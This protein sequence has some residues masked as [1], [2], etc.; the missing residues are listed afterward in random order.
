MRAREPE[1]YADMYANEKQRERVPQSPSACLCWCVNSHI[2]PLGASPQHT[3]TGVR[4]EEE[5]ERATVERGLAGQILL[6]SPS[7]LCLLLSHSGSVCLPLGLT[8]FPLCQTHRASLLLRG[9][10]P[11]GA[12]SAILSSSYRPPL[13]LWSHITQPVRKINLTLG[14]KE[15]DLRDILGFVYSLR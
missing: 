5:S 12:K 9:G 4:T 14:N 8:S 7:G 13:S 1:H 3:Q 11:T 2:P 10:N 6:S 15:D